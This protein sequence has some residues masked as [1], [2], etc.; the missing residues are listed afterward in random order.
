MK[1]YLLFTAIFVVL[2][3]L[4]LPNNYLTA[5]CMSYPLPLEQ[6]AAA[7]SVIVQGKVIEQSCYQ[8]RDG[9]IYTLNLIDVQAYLKGNLSQTQVGVITIGGI[10]GNRAQITYPALQLNL[11]DE[12][13]LFLE[14]DNTDIDDKAVRSSR[15][16]LLQS[17]TYGDAQGAIIYQFGKYVDI[18]YRTYDEEATMLEKISSLTNET[19][20]TPAG[21]V[22]RPRPYTPQEDF[23][24]QPITSFS[25]SVSNAGTIVPADFLTISGSGFGAGA[26]SVFYTNADDGGA[27][28]TSSGIA[29]DNVSWSDGSIVNKIAMRAGNGPINVNGAA[30][31]GSNL[32]IQ[33]A[34]LN[35]NST[36]SG[37][38]VSTRQR[39]YLVD[40][41]G[42]GGYTFR[43]NT[44]SGFATD[45]PATEAFKRAMTTWTC[46]TFVNWRVGEDTNFAYGLDGV[47]TVTYDN[48]L[49]AGV[50][51]RLTNRLAGSAT[52]GCFLTNTVWWVDEMD[53]QVVNVPEA[54]S[55]WEYGPSL[56]S[57]TE[58]DLESALLHELGHG[59][60]LGHVIDPSDVMHFALANGSSVRTLHANDIT[61]GNAKMAYS[62][63]YPCFNPATVN[64]PMTAL[65]AGNCNT[66]LPLDLLYFAGQWDGDK[67]ALE[68]QTVFE[69]NVDRFEVERSADGI[70]FDHIATVTAKGN[71]A[72]NILY[73]CDDTQPLKGISYYRL[74]ICDLDASFTYSDIISIRNETVIPPFHISTNPAVNSIQVAVENAG[75]Y[76]LVNEA[77]QVVNE[78]RLSAGNQ[79]IIPGILPSGTYFLVDPV[80]NFQE[81]VV[82]IRSF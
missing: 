63:L 38:G 62:I 7:A 41:N 10:V 29:S 12:Y 49:P 61:G 1:N 52:G 45:I 19:A 8:D 55:P 33:Y 82:L 9:N 3:A 26:G 35:I 14:K 80:S 51:A 42:L 21:D 17:L 60:G 39:Y 47:N 64:G 74:K 54:G 57:P 11:S 69:Q 78:V 50:Y 67:V 6:R 22:F 27:T 40:K 79:E 46:N 75:K 32:T 71:S 70:R 68:W 30:T 31:S 77:G 66:I 15:P 4:I 23:R 34:H 48:T 13:V 65:S 59:H 44:P 53:I 16:G 37:F 28:F 72:E 20:R 2:S 24:T 73:N 43:F 25:P 58:Y 81:K 5:Q 76:I 56:P 36:F 18:Y